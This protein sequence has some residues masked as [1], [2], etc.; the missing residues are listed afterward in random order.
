M[1]EEGAAP[2]GAAPSVPADGSG[3]EQDGHDLADL[4]EPHPVV[5]GAGGDV[6]VVDVERDAGGDLGEGVLDDGG[7]AGTGVTAS[8]QIGVDP[9]ALDL[10]GVGGDG[11]DLGLEHDPAVLDTGE[12][13]AGAHEFGHAGSVEGSAV[14]GVR[15]DPD[16]L[17]E[18]GDTGRHE[19]VQFGG[20]DTAHE[21]VG[22]HGGRVVDLQDGLAGTDG[23]GRPPGGGDLVPE[24]ADGLDGTDDGRTAAAPP[25]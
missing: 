6:E 12:G 11:T 5:G 10:A 20:P 4:T 21:R 1:A 18:H 24:V 14:A 8:A 16:L 13:T 19:G 9:H 3:S 22:G 15:R 25:L 2:A 23:A 17:G 7:H